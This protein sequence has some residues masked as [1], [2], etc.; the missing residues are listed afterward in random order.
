FTCQIDDA[1][2]ALNA[3]HPRPR[4]HRI[5]LE[6]LTARCQSRP[7]IGRAARQRHDLVAALA[8]TTDQACADETRTAGD[9]DTHGSVFSSMMADAGRLIIFACLGGMGYHAR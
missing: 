8:Q 5:A 4:L 7:R 6:D 9:P 3:V 2:A 1:V